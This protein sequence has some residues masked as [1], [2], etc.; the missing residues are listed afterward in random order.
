[1]L[2]VLFDAISNADQK[3]DT[4]PNPPFK[5]KSHFLERSAGKKEGRN[6]GMGKEIG[7]TVENYYYY[8]YA[9]MPLTKYL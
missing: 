2:L 1:L 4:S 7:C 3:A 9:F 5:R 6:G 8:S